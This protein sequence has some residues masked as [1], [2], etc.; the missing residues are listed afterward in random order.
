MKFFVFAFFCF[1]LSF[2]PFIA[3]ASHT[4]LYVSSDGE[5]ILDG[6]NLGPGE[7]PI[8]DEDDYAY[9]KMETDGVH[10]IWN[11]KDMGLGHSPQLSKGHI[12][13]EREK[14]FQNI[15]V[16]D[17]TEVPG[18]EGAFSPEIKDGNFVFFKRIRKI[19]VKDSA[20][21]NIF[22]YYNGKYYCDGT[23]EDLKIQY[24]THER[25][26]REIFD[27]EGDNVICEQKVTTTGTEKSFIVFN[28]VVIGEGFSPQV[29]PN[30]SMY[31]KKQSFGGTETDIPLIYVNN[32]SVG[33]GEDFEFSDDSFIFFRTNINGEKELVYNGKNL[34]EI[35]DEEKYVFKDGN[36]GY[37]KKQTVKVRDAE[38]NIDEE[39]RIIV[40]FN[41][42]NRGQGTIDWD[43]AHER[44]KIY[45][46]GDNIA[47]ERTRE[48]TVYTEGDDDS[49]LDLIEIARDIAGTQTKEVTYVV[50][51][52]RERTDIVPGT[53]RM[54]DGYFG[55]AKNHIIKEE[56]EDYAKARYL[57][58]QTNSMGANSAKDEEYSARV[59]YVYNEKPFI[60]QGFPDG[61]IKRLTQG[62]A[63]TIIVKDGSVAYTQNNTQIVQY[64]SEE[65]RRKRLEEF[66]S[67]MINGVNRGKGDITTLVIQEDFYG[68]SDNRNGRP[69]VIINGKEQAYTGENIQFFS[70]PD[71]KSTSSQASSSPIRPYYGEFFFINGRYFVK[72]ELVYIRVAPSSEHNLKN[73]VGEYIKVIGQRK[74]FT[75]AKTGDKIE[76]VKISS[77]RKA[78]KNTE[79]TATGILL[80]N[81]NTFSLK[82]PQETISLLRGEISLDALSA[83]V[84]DRLTLEIQ[85]S[86]GNT[87]KILSILN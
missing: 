44:Q 11:G 62:N 19:G 37:T 2:S 71:S 8:V 13:F 80:Q 79:K 5:I 86:V 43:D 76:A 66:P 21:G 54:E 69:F 9:E 61:S 30:N 38:G 58:Y 35:E 48:A 22:V 85:K 39:E 18:S 1:A 65:E 15:I 53:L 40:Y 70:A 41:G 60:Y 42:I 82:T 36:I 3:E 7:N 81:E 57:Y 20:Q 87:W 68:F 73:L 50:F 27:F 24:D 16:F 67:L 74:P 77:I 84:R 83:R 33:E 51:N 47:F 55:F 34:G 26:Y 14:N 6:E 31:Y 46:S 23:E 72:S 25:P 28:G 64:Y 59:K 52:G 78:E 49:D 32:I 10:I 75:V 12:L 29:S 63:D 56:D 45:I 4:F 17:G